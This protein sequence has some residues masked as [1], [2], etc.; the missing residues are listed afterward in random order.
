MAAAQTGPGFASPADALVSVVIPSYNS[1]AYIRATLE[2]VLA[3]SH[4][5]LE[6]IV[7]DDCSTD[8][9]VELV[10]QLV[11]REPRMRLICLSS[12][13]GAPAYPRN[14]GVRAATGAWVAFLDADDLWHPRKLEW[15]MRAIAETGVKMCST[16]MKDFRSQQQVRHDAPVVVPRQPITLGMQLMKYRTPAS[17]VVVERQWML[18]HP[19]NEDPSFKAREDFDC[20]IRIH[21][22]FDHSLKLEFPFVFYRVQPGQI[23]GNKLQ[24]VMRHFRILRQ[25]RFRSGKRL[26]LLAAFYTFTHFFLSIYIRQVRRR[27]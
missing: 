9:T 12:N 20:F 10:G 13:H 14:A 4:A 1:A 15:Q 26:G 7:V 6:I 27:L 18:E 19:F 3:Q 22:Y 11:L 8:A 2:S 17:S 16:Q 23:S 25:Y 5:N 21:E 24:M